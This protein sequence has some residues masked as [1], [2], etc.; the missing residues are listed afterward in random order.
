MKSKTDERDVG[1]EAKKKKEGRSKGGS[2][3][4]G[5]RVAGIKSADPRKG[6]ILFIVMGGPSLCHTRLY[7]TLVIQHTI[8]YRLL[9]Y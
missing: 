4:E 9:I 7:C 5:E 6:L 2:K 3:R 1:R 8:F